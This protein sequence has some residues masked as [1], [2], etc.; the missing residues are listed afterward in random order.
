MADHLG[1]EKGHPTGWGSGNN[2][3]GNYPK[4]I[5]TDAGTVGVEMPRDRN[6]TFAITDVFLR[7]ILL[8]QFGDN[9]VIDVQ[10][11]SAKSH[12]HGRALLPTVTEGNRR[13]YA[14]GPID[15]RDGLR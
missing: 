14:A 13:G 2:R 8:D 11:R 15:H 7:Q 9:P 3:N 1:Y 6:T 10:P 12:G 4:T 5:Q